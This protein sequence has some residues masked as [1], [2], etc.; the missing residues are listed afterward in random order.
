MLLTLSSIYTG[1][2]VEV[3]LERKIGELLKVVLQNSG[4][5]GW[6]LDSMTCTFSH[7]NQNSDPDSDPIAHTYVIPGIPYT[8]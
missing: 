7:H 1:V 8:I 3:T 4:T 5:D 2:Q 6:L